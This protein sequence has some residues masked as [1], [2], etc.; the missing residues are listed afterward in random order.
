MS[1]KCC[2]KTEKAKHD[3]VHHRQLMQVIWDIYD[4]HRA[5]FMRIAKEIL[6]SVSNET[7]WRPKPMKEKDTRWLTNGRSAE[8]ILHGYY[9]QDSEGTP[10]WVILAKRLTHIFPQSD[11]RVLHLNAFIDWM[12]KPKM[13]FGL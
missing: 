3:Q 13:I 12:L 1:E 5:V 9:I 6:K 10:F 7:R 4:R 11:W 2:G 8:S